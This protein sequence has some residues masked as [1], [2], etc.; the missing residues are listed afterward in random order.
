MLIS[1]SRRA[2]VRAKSKKTDIRKALK[3]GLVSKDTCVNYLYGSLLDFDFEDGHVRLVFDSDNDEWRVRTD[4]LTNVSVDQWRI[5]KLVKLTQGQWS[6]GIGEGCF[7]EAADAVGVSINLYPWKVDDSL[8]VNVDEEKKPPMRN[9]PSYALFKAAHSGDLSEVRRLLDAGNDIEVGMQGRT[10]LHAAIRTGAF[11]VAMELLKRGADPF[12]TYTG[13]MEGQVDA[14]MEAAMSNDL[15]D[16][17]AAAMT[18][19]LLQRG[20]DPIGARDGNTPLLMAETRDKHEMM[21]TL[22]K[23][24]ATSVGVRVFA[25]AH[26]VLKSGSGIMSPSHIEY[27][28]KTILT[29]CRHRAF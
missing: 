6:D 1:I 11:D 25:L 5:D 7:D 24:G 12:A 18:E 21:A 27:S 15:S 2:E 10:P 9:R 13:P 4:Y 16:K 3:E 29:G 22:R 14:L 19:A 28:S 23:H 8:V 17:E 26:S 20:V